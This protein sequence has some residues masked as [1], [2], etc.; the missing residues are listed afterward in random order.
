MSVVVQERASGRRL[1]TVAAV[2]SELDITDGADDA[3]LASLIDQASDAVAG[4]CNRVFAVET[5]AEHL[6][7]RCPRA[8]ILLSRWPLISLTS[9]TRNGEALEVVATEVDDTEGGLYRLDADGARTD[10]P[11]G[12]LILTYSAGYVL[13]GDSGRTLPYDVERATLITVKGNYMARTRDPLIRSETVDGAGA[14]SYFAG[15]HS[16]LPTEAEALL[17]PYRNLVF[18]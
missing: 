11:S 2:K 13:P 6:T 9:T 14:T 18:G 5:V 16:Q 15:T 8:A 4:W 7:L 10:W 1:T 3:Y 17:T 12:T